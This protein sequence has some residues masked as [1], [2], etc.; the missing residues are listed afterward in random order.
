MVDHLAAGATVVDVGA[1]S[2]Y[3]TI[4]AASVVGERGHVFAFEPNPSVAEELRA[5]VRQN[6][7]D[8][9]VT[10]VD[11]ALADKA[12]RAV[13]F[14]ASSS[15]FNTGMS[16]LIPTWERGVSTEGRRMTVDTETFDAWRRGQGLHVI[17]LVEIDAE[18]AED[19]VIRGMRETLA[20]APPAHIIIETAEASEAYHTLG[21]V[22]YEATILER[23]S[24]LSN[25]LFTYRRER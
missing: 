6:G 13:D 12:A 23:V 8:R 24:E 21:S 11:V 5:H 15:D 9:R 20:Q 7:F 4:L 14:Y 3:H 2:G 25:V 1:N 22:G 19:R 16:S 10:T 17:D 18:G